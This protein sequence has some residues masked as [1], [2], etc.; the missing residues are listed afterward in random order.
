MYRTIVK[1]ILGTHSHSISKQPIPQQT[2]LRYRSDIDGLRSLAV[3][4][5]IAFHAFPQ[6]ISGGFVGVDIFFVISGYLISN[7][8]YS[9]LCDGT[10]SFTDFY[11]R[12][13]RRILPTLVLILSVCI[14]SG[15]ILL[16]P[17]EYKQVGKHVAAGA[18]FVSNFILW[19]ESGYFDHA[20][21]TK[22]LLHLWSL[23]IEEQFYLIWP[24][25]IYISWKRCRVFKVITIA[26][27]ISF[28]LNISNIKNDAIGTFY[29]PV[30]RF[31]ELLAGAL[32]ALYK[33]GEHKCIYSKLHSFKTKT[34]NIFTGSHKHII[35][36]FFVLLGIC[37]LTG[38]ILHLN[39]AAAFP[40]WWVLIPVAGTT[41]IIASGRDAW[42]SRVLLGN[43]LA[44][45]VGI[46][47]YPLYLW[48][49]PLLTFSK[50]LSS[51]TASTATTLIAIFIS[52]I[53]SILTYMLI[54][55]PLRFGPYR[56]EK[57][58]GLCVALAIA[59]TTGYCIYNKN[60]LN[61][62]VKF[63]QFRK[64]RQL[65]VDDVSAHNKENCTNSQ[66]YPYTQLNKDFFCM[67]SRESGGLPRNVIIGDSHAYPM[68]FGF[69]NLYVRQRGEDLLMLGAPG[70]PPLL[71][72]ESFEQGSKE[73]C[74]KLIDTLLEK[75]LNDK[76]VENVILVNRGP[77]YTS[78]KGFGDTDKHQRIIRR[79]DASAPESNSSAYRNAL[80]ATI[81]ELHRKRKQT[82]LVM[83]PPEL[84]FEPSS[85]LQTR[86]YMISQRKLTDCT[87]RYD[88]YRIR[89]GEFRSI[90]SMVA[91]E[92]KSILLLDPSSV[93]C[94]TQ[95]CR[96]YSNGRFLYSDNNHLSAWGAQFIVSESSIPSIRL[97]TTSKSEP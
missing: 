31:W 8:I 88:E 28:T 32:L 43:K 10:F 20:A 29:S 82:I 18:G 4:S 44:V 23:G 35:N 9:E 95:A 78:G 50:I 2:P 47:S 33:S 83:P 6:T 41:L 14:L 5:V 37:L 91:D 15:Y 85:C 73:V 65:L 25:I 64:N 7:I 97:Q 11:F 12:R 72:L 1:F 58:A 84:G 42:I 62:R 74:S 71:G 69:Y 40:G 3:L 13:I 38:I 46:I 79:V 70:C 34:N 26:I 81:H 22:P 36:E 93:L 76:N 19:A 63:D 86:P 61:D 77:L 92:Y 53:F 24:I 54:E 17:E 30:T 94:D 49:W 68:Y 52:F 66:R 90:V 60:G 87:I 48:H 51:G 45:A 96:A 55:H 57:V 89:A 27:F 56:K 39:P 59:G 16:L 21:E 80:A 75:I 67:E